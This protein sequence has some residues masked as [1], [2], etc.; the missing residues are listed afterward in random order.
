M[1]MCMCV[2]MCKRENPGVRR[3]KSMYV[4][5]LVHQFNLHRL[6]SNLDLYPIVDIV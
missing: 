4:R 5:Q 3:Y 1:C 6:I 2:H